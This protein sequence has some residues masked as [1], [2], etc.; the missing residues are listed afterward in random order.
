MIR[1]KACLTSMLL[2]LL[3]WSATAADMALQ[4][5]VASIANLRL[6]VTTNAAKAMLPVSVSAD[7]SQP[8]PDINRVIVFVHGRLRDAAG[9][10]ALAKAAASA[11]GDAGRSTL[12]VV[13][14]FLAEP[15]GRAHTLADDA[16]RWST[17]GWIGGEPAVQPGPISSFEALDA[18]LARLASRTLLPGLRRVVIA[19]HSA[20]GQFVQRYAVAGHGAKLLAERDV[21][22]RYV[23]ANPSSYVWFGAQR[24]MPVDSAKCP[25]FDR[26]K[27]GIEAAPAYAGATADLEARYIARDV[28]YLLGQADTGTGDD[29]L[30]QGCAAMAQGPTRYARGMNYLFSLELRHPN[31]VRHRIIN[32]WDV[33]HDADRVFGS[34]CG[35]A[36]LFDWPGCPTL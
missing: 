16:L 30:D 25:D 10:M 33:G 32:I 29:V 36:A 27:Y 17:S 7:W 28:V 13:P 21:A 35:L 12:L 18:V 20:G 11:A 9:T 31:L 23:V 1:C 22:L 26:W 34:A 19:G 14:Q 5:P 2:L 3:S 4:K 24:P 8:L 15:D 6:P